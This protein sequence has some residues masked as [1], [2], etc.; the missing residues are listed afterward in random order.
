MCKIDIFGYDESSAAGDALAS[1]QLLHQEH[2]SRV[3]VDSIMR[4]RFDFSVGAEPSYIPFLLTLS[5]YFPSMIS[6]LKQGLCERRIAKDDALVL[7]IV[8]H[9]YYS[10]CQTRQLRNH[11]LFIFATLCKPDNH[12][13]SILLL[14]GEEDAAGSL[15]HLEL[16]HVSIERGGF[17]IESA[18]WSSL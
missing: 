8:D 12:R 10:T 4:C 18:D 14:L 6:L 16:K 15:L 5:E 17:T 2:E 3:T 13:P 7:R 9:Q 1:Q 11:R